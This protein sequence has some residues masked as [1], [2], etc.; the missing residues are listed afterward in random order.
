MKV[1]YHKPHVRRLSFGGRQVVSTGLDAPIWGDFY[2]NAM[3]KTWPVFMAGAVVVF[4]A[5]NLIFALLF[6]LV[7]GC[8][9]NLPPEHPFY[10]FYFSVETL[11]TVGYGYMYPQTHYGH[12]VASTE[13]FC[14]LVYAAVMT[15]LIFARFSRPKARF[16]FARSPTISMHDGVRTFSVRLAN[17]RHNVLTNASARL[18]YLRDEVSAEGV[19]Y[20][21]FY[22]LRLQRSEN[23]TF[24]LSW[25]LFHTIDETSLLY[26]VRPEDLEAMRADFIITAQG[27]DESYGSIVNARERYSYD[28]VRW[29]HRYVDII[30]RKPNGV[31]HI[32]MAKFHDVE[33]IAAVIEAAGEAV[34][35]EAIEVKPEELEPQSE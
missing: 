8:I 18:W 14:G 35:V 17:A 29:E 32:D 2:H 27:L 11:S 22:E 28:D 10:L 23:P 33:P 7:P 1:H 26:G 12:V 15:G 3:T 16:I 25:A 9:A 24:A 21:R 20:R 6:A 4:L 30:R 31:I 19:T 5:L 13:M 34:L